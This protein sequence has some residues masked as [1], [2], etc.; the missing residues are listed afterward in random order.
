MPS[1]PLIIRVDENAK[2]LTQDESFSGGLPPKCIFDKGKTGCGGTTIA[3]TSSDNY[4]IAVPFI[5]LVKN[6]VAQNR[7]VLGVYGGVGDDE[8]KAYCESNNVKKIIVTYDSIEKIMQFINPSDFKLLVDEYHILFTQY[9]LANSVFGRKVAVKKILDNYEKFSDYCFMSA[10][11]LEDDFIL[12]ELK[13]LTQVAALW[14][15]I[16]PIKVDSVRCKDVLC[17]TVETIMDYINGDNYGNAYIFINSLRVIERLIKMTGL[18]ESQYRVIYSE[19]NNNEY[20]FVRSAVDD[21]P[22]LINFVTSAAFEGVDFYDENGRIYIVSDPDNRNSL[23][24]IS[25]S[26]MQIAGRIRDSKYSDNIFHFYET[27]KYSENISYE[28]YKQFTN[29]IASDV[30]SD[31]K[32]LNQLSLVVRDSLDLKKTS[33]YLTKNE[34]DYFEYDPNYV[35]VDLYNYR[36]TRVIY[37]SKC[38][39][40][41]IYKQHGFEVNKYESKCLLDKQIIEPKKEK[42]LKEKVELIRKTGLFGPKGYSSGNDLYHY[43][44]DDQKQIEKAYEILRGDP[45]IHQAITCSKIG[46]KGI[47][48]LGYNRQLIK[49]E[50][51][52]Y[53]KTGN[54]KKITDMLISC[55]VKEGVFI[56]NK[57]IKEDIQKAYKELG[58]T[59]NANAT[60]IN[61]YFSA[62]RVQKKVGGQMKWGWEIGRRRDLV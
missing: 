29:V 3:L 16:T 43:M 59:A 17:T 6:K 22:R 49:R 46:Y 55:G 15:K 50:V 48:I 21:K 41:E 56:L 35:K 58:I 39:L 10:T 9:G 11:P 23:V 42:S 13:G 52:K 25:T 54:I 20:S 33:G 30:Q 40:G 38:E 53:G 5:A 28:D 47:E 7:N 2:Y 1:T 62:K 19:S 57:E 31:V 61:K 14:S 45:L 32:L 44:T 34:D 26:F 8:I 18:L 36:L 60:D 4:V 24:D 37:D 27:N 51:I 12:D